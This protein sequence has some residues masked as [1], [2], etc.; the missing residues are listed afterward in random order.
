MQ[1]TK[2]AVRYAIETL[3]ITPEK[4]FHILESSQ[5]Y[6]GE[7]YSRWLAGKVIEIANE[8]GVGYSKL[9]VKRFDIIQ[10]IVSDDECTSYSK[11]F[12]DL[13]TEKLGS[14]TIWVGIIN[15]NEKGNDRE[16]SS[17]SET[18]GSG[19]SKVPTE[20]AGIKSTDDVLSF[21]NRPVDAGGS[22]EESDG[23]LGSEENHDTLD[24]D[25]NKESYDSMSGDNEGLS[26]DFNEEYTE[27]LDVV[28]NPIYEINWYDKVDTGY[29]NYEFYES[30]PD[31][32]KDS[33]S[34]SI[35][36]VLSGESSKKCLL[37]ASAKSRGILCKS[38]GALMMYRACMLAD[39]YDD[40][41]K[42]FKFSFLCRTEFLCDKDNQGII[43]Y[44]LKYFNYTGFTMESNYI[45]DDTLN[46]GRYAFVECTP[47]RNG[48]SVQDGFVLADKDSGISLRYSKSNVDMFDYFYNEYFGMCVDDVLADTRGK[49]YDVVKGLSSAYGYLYN[50][51]GRIFVLSNPITDNQ[52]GYVPGD[53]KCVFGGRYVPITNKNLFNVIAYYG[54]SESLEGYGMFSHITDLM[55]GHEKYNEI[56]FNCLPLFL[57]NINSKFIGYHIHY[58]NS[59]KEGVFKNYFKYGSKLSKKL[60]EMGEVYFSFEAKELCSICDDIVKESTREGIKF[61]LNTSSI[62]SLRLK[63]SNKDLGERYL[64]ALSSLK[65]YISN[66]YRGI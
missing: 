60:L 30:L 12:L 17:K 55:T 27:D 28:P 56:V 37:F 3:G 63:I 4:F 18:R 51:N 59:D 44:F 20:D 66:L 5:G 22:N 2:D 9:L 21:M 16:G 49:S 26:S 19:V 52:E 62:N 1:K 58:A 13:I 54:L 61:D 53:L 6:D 65:G 34:L 57:Y 39:T 50:K 38:L 31:V 24:R 11:E 40:L 25:S 42:E 46:R 7:D 47:I 23:N 64:S 41:G 14:D 29:G 43:D 8:D 33:D 10:S 45:F 35:F 15:P 48:G 36:C 32:I